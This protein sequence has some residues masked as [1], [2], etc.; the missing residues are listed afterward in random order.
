MSP[1][2]NGLRNA[3]DFFLAISLS[4]AVPS[5]VNIIGA[6]IQW[7]SSDANDG[8]EDCSDGVEENS[9]LC[10]NENPP[11]RRVKN[12]TLISPL[13]FQRVPVKIVLSRNPPA[14]PPYLLLFFQKKNRLN[15]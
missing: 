11:E 4:W 3:S 8:Q 2:D 9:Q 7:T 15:S 13:Y 5:I 1:I 10:V 6:P 14:I 12:E